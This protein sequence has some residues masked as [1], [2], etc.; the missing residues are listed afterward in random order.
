MRLRFLQAAVDLPVGMSLGR[1]TKELPPG[2]SREGDSTGMS[3]NP[4]PL[5]EP[6]LHP[7]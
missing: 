4:T 1:A 3:F 7:N 5:E 2:E 6:L